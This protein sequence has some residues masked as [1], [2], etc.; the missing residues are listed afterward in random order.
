MTGQLD[1]L[2]AVLVNDADGM[3]AILMLDRSAHPAGPRRRLA[4][5]GGR[6][7]EALEAP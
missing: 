5:S 2:L 1:D 7:R 3:A 4:A 6:L